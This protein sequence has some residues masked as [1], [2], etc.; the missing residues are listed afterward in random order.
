MTHDSTA[1]RGTSFDFFTTGALPAPEL[2]EAGA[3]AIA[4]E[5]FGLRVRARS[6]GSQQDANFLLTTADGDDAV[7]GVLKVSNGAFG[8]AD[9]AAQDAAA[10]HLDR[11]GGGLRGG[12]TPPRAR[13]PPP[14]L[15]PRT[16]PLARGPRPPPGRTPGG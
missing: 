13:A 11:R 4:A 3:A 6:L 12:T 8:P 14:T 7:V 9:I 1:A 5:H 10:D 2:D 15:P 16:H